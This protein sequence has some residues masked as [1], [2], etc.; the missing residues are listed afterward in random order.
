MEVVNH[1][2]I[3]LDKL[4]EIIEERLEIS[5]DEKEPLLD[6][7]HEIRRLIEGE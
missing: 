7:L 4:R 1:I 3:R 2:H 6:E 5:E